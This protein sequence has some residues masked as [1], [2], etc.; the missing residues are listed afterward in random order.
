MYSLEGRV[1]DAH[2]ICQQPACHPALCIREAL[3]PLPLR[4]W[5]SFPLP[6][7]STLAKKENKNLLFIIAVI[8]S[9]TP[10]G[11]ISI[12]SG[13]KDTVISHNLCLHFPTRRQVKVKGPGTSL[14]NSTKFLLCG[15][16]Y[17]L[18]TW[19]LEKGS[20]TLLTWD[21]RSSQIILS[22][23]AWNI[24]LFYSIN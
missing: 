7:V 11:P 15:V 24:C 9:E 13:S 6:S 4:G 1:K 16:T 12:R 2:G 17:S 20:H 8:H 3:P 23:S 18:S 14:R 21:W 10:K 5:M 22:S 19:Y